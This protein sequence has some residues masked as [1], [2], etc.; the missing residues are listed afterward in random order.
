MSKING[1]RSR[2]ATE[3]DRMQLTAK[4]QRRLHESEDRHWV[5]S[6]GKAFW[7]DIAFVKAQVKHEQRAKIRNDCLPILRKCGYDLEY[8]LRIDARKNCGRKKKVVTDWEAE[9]RKRVPSKAKVDDCAAKVD[10]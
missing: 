3:R 7:D 5:M 1:N 10:E 4:E 8:L 2:L 6:I 9:Y